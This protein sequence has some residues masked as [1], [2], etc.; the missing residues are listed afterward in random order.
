MITN[1]LYKTKNKFFLVL[2]AKDMVTLIPVTNK[3]S[4]EQDP[5]VDGMFANRNHSRCFTLEEVNLLGM[6]LV[7]EGMAEA[8]ADSISVSYLRHNVETD[9]FSED[10]MEQHG[11]DV[12]EMMQV[13]E[14][15]IDKLMIRSAHA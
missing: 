10:A 1:S 7:K 14:D 2:L 3:P 6:T 12:E 15:K 4:T 9:G 5:P 11:F 13:I 8:V